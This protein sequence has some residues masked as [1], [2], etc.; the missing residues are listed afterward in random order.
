RKIKRVGSTKE[1]E[2]DVRILTATNEDLMEA[3]E[4]GDFR[5][6]LYH[7]NNEFSIEIPYLEERYEDLPL[8]A[9]YFLQKANLSLNKNM[10]GFSE[11]V[12]AAFTRYH[13]P[14]N[15]REMQ[16]VIKRAV[17]LSTGDYVEEGSLP[18]EV[19][20]SKEL[21]LSNEKF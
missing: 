19:F 14:G 12:K 15:L 3:V 2:V 13:W 18:K 5:E 7:R 8:F 4:R 21:D 16:N 20:K 17:L 9:D 11:E 10:L 1:I 6:D